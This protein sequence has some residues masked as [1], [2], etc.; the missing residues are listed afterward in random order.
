MNTNT[1]LERKTDLVKGD[2]S[3]ELHDGKVV[4]EGDKGRDVNDIFWMVPKMRQQL[5]CSRQREP[6]HITQNDVPT[7][8]AGGE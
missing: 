7:S 1:T 5:G 6:N 4:A 8:R 2:E 3:V